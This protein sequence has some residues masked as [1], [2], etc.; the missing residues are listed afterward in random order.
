[1]RSLE[2]IARI[3]FIVLTGFVAA[4]GN[5]GLVTSNDAGPVAKADAKP[6]NAVANNDTAAATPD[7]SL[8]GDDTRGGSDSQDSGGGRDIA[9]GGTETGSSKAETGADARGSDA[10]GG[11]T[12]GSFGQCENG[13][14]GACAAAA[15]FSTCM[16]DNCDSD[17]RDCFG[18]SYASATFAGPCADYMNCV[19][20]CPCDATAK[21]C[22]DACTPLLSAG[23]CLSCLTGSLCTITSCGIPPACLLPSLPGPDGGARIDGSGGS[24]GA[25][26]DG[27]FGG[28]AAAAACC[29]VIEARLGASVGQLCMSAVTG[30]TD[31]QCDAALEKYGSLCSQ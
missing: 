26:V 5:N 9:F 8:G 1:M 10:G 2:T 3:G 27:S 17:V 24:D 19:W 31:A 6:D 23:T 12:V 4:C 14:G 30:S 16:T 29:S 15:A 21:T 25:R 7:S 20:K 11:R 13:A 22:Q 28:C 18:P